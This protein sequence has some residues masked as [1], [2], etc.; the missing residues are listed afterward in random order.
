MMSKAQDAVIEAAV[1]GPA[2]D[3][4]AA[5]PAR[6]P[7]RTDARGCLMALQPDDL[8]SVRLDLLE[9]TSP[10]E[11]AVAR[12]NLAQPGIARIALKATD[13][14]SVHDRLKRLGYVVYTEPAVVD[15][16]GSRF[17]VFCAEDP[18]GVVLEFMEF[19]RV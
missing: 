4:Q 6:R 2:S 15:M 11:P 9:W 1:E 3:A 7:G 18:D 12:K 19:L 16:G 14:Q 13:A 10:V 8:G 17:K 5:R